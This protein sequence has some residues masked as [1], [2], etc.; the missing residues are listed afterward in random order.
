MVE[1]FL[2]L[3]SFF[4]SE[5]INEVPFVRVLCL[6]GPKYGEY[7]LI[8]PVLYLILPINLHL[9]RKIFENEKLQQ[10]L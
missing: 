6:T 5:L 2:S 8:Q 4:T 1:L 10:N 3:V 9:S 7:H